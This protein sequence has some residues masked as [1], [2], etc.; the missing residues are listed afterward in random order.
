MVKT[1]N[2]KY[3]LYQRKNRKLNKGKSSSQKSEEIIFNG[4]KF[5]SKFLKTNRKINVSDTVN[6]LVAMC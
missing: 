5:I 1:V 2:G 6:T 3:Q 4:N